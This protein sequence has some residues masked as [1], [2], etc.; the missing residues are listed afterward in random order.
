MKGMVAKKDDW[1]IED[2]KRLSYSKLWDIQRNYFHSKGIDA[3]KGEVPFYVSSNCFI[4]NA[5]AQMVLRIIQ[6]AHLKAPNQPPAFQ[7]VELGA[8]TGKFSYYFLRFLLD[9]LAASKLDLKFCYTVTDFSEK[10][11]DSIQ[12]NYSF[13]ALKSN[14]AENQEVEFVVWDFEAA[15]KAIVKPGYTPIII[16]NYVFDCIRQDKFNIE[17]GVL[18]EVQVALNNRYL[19]FDAENPKTLRDLEFKESN[20]AVDPNTYYQDP[21]LNAVLMHYVDKMKT[22]TEFS[23]PVGAFNFIDLL[24]TSQP[25]Y[26]LIGDKGLSS[27]QDFEA[28]QKR[29]LMSYDGCYSFLLNFDA[30]N[31]YFDQSGGDYVGTDYVYTFGVHLYGNKEVK[32]N[33][34]KIKI[35]FHEIFSRFGPKEYLSLCQEYQGSCYRFKLDSIIDFIKLSNYDPD[36]YGIVHDRLIELVPAINDYNKPNLLWVLSKVES[37]VYVLGSAFDTFNLLGIFY[38]VLGNVE[39]A[40]RLF[41][42]SIT[43]LGASGPVHHNLGVLYTKRKDRN[44]AIYHFEKSLEIERKNPVAKSKLMNLKGGFWQRL[45]IPLSKFATIAGIIFLMYLFVRFA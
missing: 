29:E 4:A 20:L 5:Y 13:T 17:N 36:A 39:E 22:G 27:I 45:I 3:W 43:V 16:A 40:E 8:G 41:N 42:K 1:K 15:K 34:Q 31:Q 38:Q 24:D 37:N 28:T 25:Y 21:K 7:I 44:A 9:L 26:L 19:K 32:D 33:I 14:L 6:Q 10:I 23:L 12:D 35:D 18:H 2:A 11:I 30:I